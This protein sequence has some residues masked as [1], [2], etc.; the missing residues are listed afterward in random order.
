M[1]TSDQDKSHFMLNIRG[2]VCEGVVKGVAMQDYIKGGAAHRDRTKDKGIM[3]VCRLLL[4]FVGIVAKTPAGQT[5]KLRRNPSSN[6]WET[7][8]F[9]DPLSDSYPEVHAKLQ[10]AQ[11]ALEQLWTRYGN[12]LLR[13]DQTE[14]SS[15]CNE[16]ITSLIPD[17]STILPK[18][19]PLLDATGKMG[20][21]LMEGNFILDGSYDECFNA[22]YTGFCVANFA[23]V[24]IPEVL[25]KAGI[26]V[27]KNCSNKD[28]T[29]LIKNTNVLWTDESIVYCTAS[30]T[31]G[32]GWGAIVMVVITA[33]FAATVLASTIV[34][35]VFG[36]FIPFFF[37]P[38]GK[39][40]SQ[41][42]IVSAN[43]ANI[44]DSMK[45]S[46]SMKVDNCEKVHLSQEKQP[47]IVHSKSNTK[48]KVR[49]WDF[50]RA[51]SLFNTVPTL[52]ATNQA[53]NVIT[54]LNG[55]RVI[56]M[57][58]IILGHTHMWAFIFGGPG[59]DNPGIYEQV[60]SRF[61]F[62]PVN[63]GFV[64]VDSF[65]LIS[66]VLV[67]YLT[68]R[69]MKK[70]GRFP[71]LHFYIHRY[72]RITPTYAFV[73]F[74]SWAMMDHFAISPI[75]VTLAPELFRTCKQYW[76]TNLLYINN[77]YPWRQEEECFGWAWYLAN[78]MQFYIIS[79]LILLLAYYMFWVALLVVGILLFCS[80]TVTAVLVGVYDLQLSKFAEIAYGYNGTASTSDYDALIYTKPWS[81]IGPYLVGLVLGYLLYKQYRLPF[82]SKRKN[83]VLSFFLFVLV[84]AIAIPQ[85]YGLYFTWHGHVPTKFENVLYTSLNFFLWGLCLAIIIFVCHNGYGWVINSF[86]SMKMWIPLSRM[87][88][89][90]YLVHPVVLTVVL[91]QLQ[92]SI[93]YTD[94]TMA[95]YVV[96]IV[97]LSYGV[98]GVVCVLVE[99]P[100]GTIEIL[101]FRMLGM[102]GRTSQRQEVVAMGNRKGEK[103]GKQEQTQV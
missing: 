80:F 97:V 52:L 68:L 81:R 75:V 62:Q 24:Q 86:L 56:S 11:D 79:P 96:G 6:F 102:K 99:F 72:L 63:N 60:S 2:E 46:E 64:G 55:I 16:A 67:A 73:L 53:P 44:T 98:A 9:L 66:G 61:T 78:D 92:K 38:T 7:L 15:E 100:L 103:E 85:L 18:M 3:K 54:S 35:I 17:N 10:G 25:W 47:L 57:F 31:P 4:F 26:C 49:L 42:I 50:I 58:W 41:Q 13:E 23:V 34:D 88:F 94:I 48:N 28:I 40:E 5:E 89:N 69:E 101:V 87:T 84:G 77:F 93:H 59:V 27:P 74:F 90:A 45:S 22:N 51:F 19:L 30:K 76:W 43:A 91:G 12:T 14:V 39:E 1:I 71:F 83:A 82:T 95:F 33:I 8:H 20:A 21:G 37:G 70:K 65:F 29:I 32:Y 36:Q